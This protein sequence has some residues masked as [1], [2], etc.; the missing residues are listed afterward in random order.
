MVIYIQL[1]LLTKKRPPVD[2]GFGIAFVLLLL[3]PPL[4]ASAIGWD[5]KEGFTRRGG[6]H[7]GGIHWLE[8]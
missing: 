4:S 7:R 5:P 6:N 8:C 3:T 1:N 2:R